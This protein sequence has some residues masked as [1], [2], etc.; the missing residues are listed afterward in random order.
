MSAVDTAAA[1]RRLP[2]A[3]Q[4]TPVDPLKCST[5]TVRGPWSGPVKVEGRWRPDPDA[6]P[7]ETVTVTRGPDADSCPGDLPPEP[8]CAQAVPWTGLSVDALVHASAAQRWVSSAVPGPDGRRSGAPGD[9]HRVPRTMTY[10]VMTP[11]PGGGLAIGPAL[12]AGASACAD[13][14]ARTVGGTTLLRGTTVDRWAPT[15]GAPPT[16][17]TFL[18]VIDPRGVAWAQLGGPAWPR[19]DIDS[20]AAALRDALARSATEAGV[21][22]VPSLPV[23]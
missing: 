2:A 5:T 1:V 13:T 9:P 23:H 4:M 7:D 18:A 8:D 22:K 3:P 12:A 21:P 11:R 14:T 20:A 17:A 16:T 19:R 6:L 10:T 15:T